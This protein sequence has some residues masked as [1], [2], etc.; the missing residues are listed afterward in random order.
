MNASG[1]FKEIT[2]VRPDLNDT[3]TVLLQ[4]VGKPTKR[5]R[6]SSQPST[7]RTPAISAGENEYIRMP[8]GDTSTLN[9]DAE[10]RVTT[11]GL[12]NSK[13]K[14]YIQRAMNSVMNMVIM[15]SGTSVDSTENIARHNGSTNI[16]SQTATERRTPTPQDTE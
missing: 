2:R 16:T 8:K 14:T 13:T 1:S 15:D 9:R 3:A 11:H 7:R 6:S 12:A 5:M 10:S 4:S